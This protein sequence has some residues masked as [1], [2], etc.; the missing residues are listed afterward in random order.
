VVRTKLGPAAR[1]KASK[2]IDL[3][4]QELDVAGQHLGGVELV[5][6]GDMMSRASSAVFSLVRFR[7]SLAAERILT[8]LQF[9]RASGRESDGP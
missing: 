7:R 1:T 2:P 6:P 8:R 5:R 3:R 4:L 9:G